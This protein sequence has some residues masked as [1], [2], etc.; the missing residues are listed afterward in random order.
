MGNIANGSHASS[1]TDGWA[2]DNTDIGARPEEPGN[3][4]AVSQAN[5]AIPQES[6]SLQEAQSS[7]ALQPCLKNVEFMQSLRN[8]RNLQPVSLP[9]QLKLFSRIPVVV[10]ARLFGQTGKPSEIFA[11]LLVA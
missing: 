2:N 1:I 11:R 10:S 6:A 3:A 7:L 4:S 8:P 9:V 5:S